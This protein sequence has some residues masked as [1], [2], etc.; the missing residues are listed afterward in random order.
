[1]ASRVPDDAGDVCVRVSPQL[2]MQQGNV[3]ARQCVSVN[4]MRTVSIIWTLLLFLEHIS[5]NITV[6]LLI[7]AHIIYYNTGHVTMGLQIKFMRGMN[8]RDIKK[9]RFFFKWSSPM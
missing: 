3:A 5:K 2:M 1:M 8:T 9:N 7:R 4:V 6:N